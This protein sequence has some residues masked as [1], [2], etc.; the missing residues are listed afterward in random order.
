M[1]KMGIYQVHLISDLQSSGKQQKS[2][3]KKRRKSKEVIYCCFLIVWMCQDVV[4]SIVK[5]NKLYQLSL[6]MFTLIVFFAMK[7][8]KSFWREIIKLWEWVREMCG[9]VSTF[10]FKFTTILNR[11][12]IQFNWSGKK[13]NQ[14]SFLLVGGI[15]VWF[16]V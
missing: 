12:D 14:K 11:K 1:R 7:S 6:Q 2:K 16:N 10:Y 4:M 15:N 8:V 5:A 3:E 9:I 13:I